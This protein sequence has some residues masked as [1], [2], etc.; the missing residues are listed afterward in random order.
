MALSQIKNKAQHR[1]HGEKLRE[2]K[3]ENWVIYFKVC[4]KLKSLEL[5]FSS[6]LCVL[7][8]KSFKFTT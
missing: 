1:G 6:F 2:R 5:F 3:A 8:V 7:C 4:G